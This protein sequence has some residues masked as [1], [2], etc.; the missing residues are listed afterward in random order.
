MSSRTSYSPLISATANAHGLDPNFVEAVVIQESSGATDAFRFEPKFYARYLAKNPA[1]AGQNPRRISSSYGLMQVMYVVAKE[2]GF[3][4]EPE[5]L[6]V[7]MVGLEWGCRR[8]AV[9][10]T[11]AKGDLLS[12]AAAYNGGR[13]DNEPG[14][15]PMLRNEV[16]GRHVL[17]IMKGLPA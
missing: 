15:Q 10:M 7:P 13:A 1:Y 17:T 3:A 5:E 9:L 4:G 12:V 2:L 11:W 14:H 16:Y 6:F 8:L